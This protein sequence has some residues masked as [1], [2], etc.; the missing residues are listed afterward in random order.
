MLPICPSDQITVPLAQPVAVREIG[1][2]PQTAVFEA[3]MVGGVPLL[4]FTV[5]ISPFELALRHVP[6]WQEAE[7]VV[8]AVGT[9]T[10]LAPVA[11]VLQ[12]IVPPAQPSAVSVTLSPEQMIG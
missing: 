1:S 9:T 3:A 4:V 8:V 2:P 10:M 7:Y 6:T 12:T 11:P 5:T